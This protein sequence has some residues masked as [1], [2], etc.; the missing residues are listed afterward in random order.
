M[1]Y[2]SFSPLPESLPHPVTDFF[3]LSFWSLKVFEFVALD[4]GVEVWRTRL[5]WEIEPDGLI[6]LRE[7]VC[8][9]YKLPRSVH[10]LRRSSVIPHS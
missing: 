1:K 4:K 7:E 9:L 10:I 2:S 8:I 6:G 3:G 5:I